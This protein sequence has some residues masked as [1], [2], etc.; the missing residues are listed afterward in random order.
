MMDNLAN[1]RFLKVELNHRCYVRVQDM[2][3]EMT[4]DNRILA[5]ALNYHL[6]EQEK[7]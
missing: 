3:G 5:V 4:N 2:F 6:E 1:W 7:A